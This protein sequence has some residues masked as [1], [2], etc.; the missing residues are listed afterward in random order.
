MSDRRGHRKLRLCSKKHYETKKYFP[1][2]LIVS[3]PKRTV[4][5][6]K[7]SLPV[8]LVSF[9][10]SLPLSAYT[11]APVSSLDILHHRLKQSGLI[12]QGVYLRNVF[13]CIHYCIEWIHT[14]QNEVY[15]LSKLS[16]LDTGPEIILSIEIVK[17]FSWRVQFRH[18]ILDSNL[19]SLLKG[20]PSLVNSGN[21]N[22]FIN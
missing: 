12:P 15:S 14:M 11:N 21:N 1:K 13:I 17:D 5:I 19:C 8:D 6:L 16:N 7:V 2:K 20:M 3:I 22:I 9:R 4:T 10:L 18:H